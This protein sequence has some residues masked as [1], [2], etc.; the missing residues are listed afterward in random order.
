MIT[1]LHHVAIAVHDIDATAAFYRTTFGLPGIEAS[2]TPPD[3]GVRAAF[4]PLGN[5]RIELLQP[6]RLAPT[7]LLQLC[8][9]PSDKGKEPK[10]AMARVK[11]RAERA[12]ASCKRPA[13]IR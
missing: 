10:A 6:L 2:E 9:V 4:I 7:F 8:P 13:S 11:V 12:T 3:Q 5:C 1:G